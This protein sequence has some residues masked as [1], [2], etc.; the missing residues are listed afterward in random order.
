MTSVAKVVDDYDHRLKTYNNIMTSGV[1]GRNYGQLK[2]MI[3]YYRNQKHLTNS[4]VKYVNAR[5]YPFS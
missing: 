4:T 2:F 5:S 3:K 1:L